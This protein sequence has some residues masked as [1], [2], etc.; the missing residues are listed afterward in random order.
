M[1]LLDKDQP[2]WR[3]QKH[4]N[5]APLYSSTTGMLLDENGKRSIFDDVDL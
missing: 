3:T 1:R 4:A 2:D 5:G